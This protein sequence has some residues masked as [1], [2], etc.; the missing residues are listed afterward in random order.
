MAEQQAASAPGLIEVQVC[1]IPACGAAQLRTVRLAPGASLGDAVS[2]SGLDLPDSSWRDPSGHLR[3]AVF[4]VLKPASALAHPGDRIDITRP[5]TVDPKDA[6]RARARK[7]AA[8][9]RALRG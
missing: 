6:R 4:G 2:R 9:R 1:W 8:Q 7:A 5:L 3:L